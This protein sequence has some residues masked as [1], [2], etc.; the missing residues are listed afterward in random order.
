[1][2][3]LA[4]ALLVLIPVAPGAVSSG[5]PLELLRIPVES[6][7]VVLVLVLIPWRALRLVVAGLFGVLVVLAIILSGI[8]RGYAAVL[9]TSFDPADAQQLGDAVGV[10]ADAIGWPSVTALL[11]LIGAVAIGLAAALAWAALRVDAAIRARR[12]TGTIALTTVTAGWMVFALVGSQAGV[13]QPAAAAASADQLGS[14][15]SRASVSLQAQAELDRRIAH[16]PYAAVPASDLLA[17]LHGKDVVIVFV[18]SY[19][20]AALEDPGFSPG[21]RA[22]LQKGTAD[23]AAHGHASRS[24]WLTSSTYGGLSWLAHSSLQSGLWVDSQSAYDKVVATGRL[25]L[26]RAFREAGWHTVSD[27]PRNTR[28][29]ATGSDFYRYETLLDGENVG[30]EGPSFGY[31]HIPDQYTLKHF[32]DRFLTGPHEPVMGE[33]DLI[34][35]HTPFTPVPDLEPW[36]DIGDGSVYF[37]QPERGGSPA[38]VWQDPDAVRAAY[39]R[40]IEYSIASVLS[41][42]RNTDDP[43]LVV[44]MLGDHQA[45]PIISGEDASHDVPITII[46]RDP[47]ALGPIDGWRWQEGMLPGATAPAWRMDAFRDRF[48]TAFGAH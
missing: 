44:I 14:T 35:S 10:V 26:A 9:A 20:R 18:E 8:D 17:K 24:A 46:A 3:G 48:F 23:L 39:G 12:R 5:S 32:S 25:T 42:V 28:P 43:N 36:S 47:S 16:D 31:P 21:V 41:F 40:S 29:W 19:G 34:S 11:V 22:V 7:V 15:V 37:G 30:Y 27:I 38:E 1:M 6:I 13:A 33:I 2:L 45:A 4:V